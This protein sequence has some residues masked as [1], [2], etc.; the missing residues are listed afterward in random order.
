MQI[1][2]GKAA[3]VIKIYSIALRLA[4][5]RGIKEGESFD[6]EFWEVTQKQEMKHK[7]RELKSIQD[8]N[9]YIKEG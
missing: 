2:G 3:D 9:Q 5:K 6:K 1:F 8:L 4:R 7:F